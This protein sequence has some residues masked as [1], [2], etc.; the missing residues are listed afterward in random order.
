MNANPTGASDLGPEIA[1][2]VVELR[3]M[4]AH[5]LD[6]RIKEEEISDDVSLLEGGL[7]LDS[8]VLFEF[9]ALIEKRF[10]FEFSDQSLSPE[11]FKSL[12]VLAQHIHGMTAR[13]QSAVA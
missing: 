6:V 1:Q 13:R 7:A 10:G 9:I 8:I 11:T 2:L 4:I 3:Q 5:K 12:T